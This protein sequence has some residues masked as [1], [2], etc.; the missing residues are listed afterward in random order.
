[1]LNFPHNF[2]KGMSRMYDKSDFLNKSTPGPFTIDDYAC[3]IYSE[4]PYGDGRMIV[5]IPNAKILR[6]KNDRNI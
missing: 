3:Q 2:A 1:M 4:N 6:S 5:Q